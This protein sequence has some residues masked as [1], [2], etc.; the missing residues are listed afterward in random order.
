MKGLIC[1]AM[2]S[3]LISTVAGALNCVATLVSVDISRQLKPGEISDAGLVKIGRVTAAI[4]LVRT[5]GHT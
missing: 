1:A 2:P 4:V 5:D 3:A